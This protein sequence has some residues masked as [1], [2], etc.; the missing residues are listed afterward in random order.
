MFFPKKKMNSEAR[1]QQVERHVREKGWGME[2]EE[3]GTRV[4]GE[5]EG[6]VES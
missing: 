3:S 6:G 4:R 2:I 1:T 5:R